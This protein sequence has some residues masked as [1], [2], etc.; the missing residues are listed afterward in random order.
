M[1][2]FMPQSL[3]SC[4]WTPS[5]FGAGLQQNRGSSHG[6]S[7]LKL[8]VGCTRDSELEKNPVGQSPGF[9]TSWRMG[10]IERLAIPSAL[11]ESKAGTARETRLQPAHPAAWPRS[12]GPQHQF[13]ASGHGFWGHSGPLRRAVLELGTELP[14]SP[15]QLT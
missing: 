3:Q 10:D 9:K 1:A 5:R 8:S 12:V 4:I 14:T 2:H 13:E 15:C 7:D 6:G 11:P